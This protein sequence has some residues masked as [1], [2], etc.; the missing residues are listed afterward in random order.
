MLISYGENQRVMLTKQRRRGR[1]SWELPKGRRHRRETLRATAVREL[2]EETGVIANITELQESIRHRGI[3]WY[4]IY[5]EE[6]S[7]LTL[8]PDWHANITDADT[9]DA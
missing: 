9:L 6:E 3:Q 7:D 5:I 4:V 8:E 1:T 2:N